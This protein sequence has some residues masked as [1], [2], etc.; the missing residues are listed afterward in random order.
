MHNYS[1]IYSY[2]VVEL[3]R[4]IGYVNIKAD[5]EE[6]DTESILDEVYSKLERDTG[7]WADVVKFRFNFIINDD[8]VDLF[9]D[10]LVYFVRDGD[11]IKIGRSRKFVNRLFS[12]QTG[13]PRPLQC[14][15]VIKCN[16]YKSACALEKELHRKYK[17]YRILN[18]WFSEDILND[19]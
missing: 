2:N 7:L 3:E 19:I 12:L 5:L 17:D 4:G 6:E 11:R 15:K 9:N 18:E 8:E 10:P 1:V 13:N 14:E 16:D